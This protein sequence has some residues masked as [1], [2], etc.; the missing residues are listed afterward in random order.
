ML[1]LNVPNAQSAHKRVSTMLEAQQKEAQKKNQ[2]IPYFEIQKLAKIE[3]GY[4]A[5]LE[6]AEYYEWAKDKEFDR[7]AGSFKFEFRA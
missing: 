1:H 5:F 2:P 4:L 3:N 6:R 7:K